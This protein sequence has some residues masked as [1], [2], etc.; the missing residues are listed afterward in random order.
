MARVQRA[1]ALFNHYETYVRKLLGYPAVLCLTYTDRLMYAFRVSAQYISE[2]V[3]TLKMYTLRTQRV[4]ADVLQK[5]TPSEQRLTLCK[6]V[7][8]TLT[9][10]WTVRHAG[11]PVL[12]SGQ[13]REIRSGFNGFYFIDAFGFEVAMFVCIIRLGLIK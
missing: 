13:S 3:F 9:H 2:T 8:E 12:R 1:V 4:P 10:C 6:R 11:F 5:S 7:N